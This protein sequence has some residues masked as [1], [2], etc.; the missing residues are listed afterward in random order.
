MTFLDETPVDE[1]NEDDV[2]P[3]VPS[4]THEFKNFTA[5]I[6]T[7]QKQF[8]LREGQRFG[9]DNEPATD[10]VMVAEGVPYDISDA[11][12]LRV[13]PHS[14]NVPIGE[15]IVGQLLRD[16]FGQ[17]DIAAILAPAVSCTR[18]AQL[19]ADILFGPNYFGQ[20][21]FLVTLGRAFIVTTAD[22][23]CRDALLDELDST[24]SD[25]LAEIRAA[26]F[27]TEL[28]LEGAAD[29]FVL[30]DYKTIQKLENGTWLNVGPWAGK[31]TG[32]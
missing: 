1:S 27:G 11:S 16:R 13:D 2:E 31:R 18:M 28:T 9:P 29:V 5:D 30:A 25:I 15:A 6:G 23:A 24:F 8:F 10:L 17:T 21:P 4:I 3:D 12:L 32:R 20:Y 26:S 14:W 22:A 7:L 19:V